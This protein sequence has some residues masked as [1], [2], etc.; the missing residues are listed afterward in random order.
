MAVRPGR[1]AFFQGDPADEAYLVLEGRLRNLR[2]RSDDARISM[3]ESGPGTWAGLA[4]CSLKATYLADALAPEGAKLLKLKRPALDR[5]LS[6]AFAGPELMRALA[7]RTRDLAMLLD[8]GSASER[9]ARRLLELASE[10]DP[11]SEGAALTDSTGAVPMKRLQGRTLRIGGERAALADS[12][13]A[14]RETVSRQLSLMEKAGILEA[15][16]GE[17]LIYDQGALRRW[18][19]ETE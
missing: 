5:L 10:A 16:R 3:G 2:Y 14:A 6:D 15:G 12:I 1:A 8:G 9:L 11:E 18:A 4:E 19:G 7:S 17:I 13:G